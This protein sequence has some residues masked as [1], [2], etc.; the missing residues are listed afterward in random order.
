MRG[1]R[2]WFY[3]AICCSLLAVMDLIWIAVENHIKEMPYS[4][5]CEIVNAVLSLPFETDYKLQETKVRSRTDCML[6]DRS[7]PVFS[8]LP[9]FR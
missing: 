7:A 1:H 4:I 2:V 6:A 3:V 5:R 8:E 9:Y